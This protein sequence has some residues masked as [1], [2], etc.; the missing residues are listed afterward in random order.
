VQP[1]GAMPTKAAVASGSEGSV[2]PQLHAD[3]APPRVRVPRLELLGAFE[4]TYL[5][6]HGVDVAETTRHD[7]QW[8]AVEP[9]GH[10]VT[11]PSRVR[12]PT[13]GP[14]PRAGPPLRRQRC[15][16]GVV[17]PRARRQPAHPVRRCP[18]WPRPG[19]VCDAVPAGSAAGPDLPSHAAAPGRR[20][21]HRRLPHPPAGRAVPDRP[22]VAVLSRSLAGA[23]GQRP[24]RSPPRAASR[25]LA[26]GE[27]HKD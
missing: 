5:P 7:Q 20:R 12:T 26:S 27:Q 2:S 9:G 18:C 3:A 10:G 8:Q 21:R 16:G 14:R 22:R 13:G 6:G 15:G 17:R 19:E 24:S 1:L 25:Q 4:M 23:P 11:A